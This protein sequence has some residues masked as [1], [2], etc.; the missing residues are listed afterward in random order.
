[1]LIAFGS[2]SQQ[3]SDWLSLAPLGWMVVAPLLAAVWAV[4]QAEEPVQPARLIYLVAGLL[5]P[6]ALATGFAGAE[7]VASPGA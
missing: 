2:A 6:V 1:M 3:V 4:T 5:L 7:R